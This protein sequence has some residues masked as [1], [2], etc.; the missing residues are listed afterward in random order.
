[1]GIANLRKM[2]IEAQR[3]FASDAAGAIR[4]KDL[5]QSDRL[6]PRTGAWLDESGIQE[7][8]RGHESNAL[9]AAM[10][11]VVVFD[12]EQVMVFWNLIRSHNFVPSIEY[13]LPF[14]NV[15]IQ[16]SRPVSLLSLSDEVAIEHDLRKI[17]ESPALLLSQS[18][19]TQSDVL[20]AVYRQSDR[21]KTPVDDVA[22]FVNEDWENRSS[23]TIN[24]VR[25]IDREMD[26]EYI[27]W[28]DVDPDNM[29]ISTNCH[30]EDVR[31]AMRYRLLAAACIQYINCENVYL[32]KQGEVSEAVNRKRE[33]K[34]KS[35]LEPYYVCRIRAYSTIATPPAKVVNTA[36]GTM[37]AVTSDVWRR[38]RRY[39]CVLTSV[40]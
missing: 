38:A 39:G 35:R 2:F 20:R 8:V 3:Y 12:A 18:H 26:C 17:F 7:I 36:S 29:F 21:L 13:R 33:A 4:S 15:W 1:M 32:E 9:A 23:G 19:I 27:H 30:P 25:V 14:E 22:S 34:G 16:F 5:Y 28:E 6:I 40:A 37:Y 11:Q 10:S 24:T 31:D